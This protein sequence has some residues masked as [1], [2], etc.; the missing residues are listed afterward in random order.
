[1]RSRAHASAIAGLCLVLAACATMR[2]PQP[3]SLQLPEPPK[4]LH[5]TR[6]GNTVV[7]QWT[8]PTATTD[9][10]T[11]REAGPTQICRSMAATLVKC[12]TPVGEAPAPA[13]R[14]PSDK[15]VTQSYTDTLPS[16]LQRENPLGKV[17]YAV[18]VLNSDRRGD[19]VSKNAQVPLAQ[20]LPAPADFEAK[21][22]SQG[23]RLTWA[24]ATLPEAVPEIT[25]VYRVY[26]RPDKT[27]SPT[28]VGEVSVSGNPQPSLLDSNIEWEQTYFYFADVVTI[29]SEPGKPEV[30][31]EGEDSAE[32]KVFTHDVFPPAV[33]TGLQA[34]FSGPGQQAF[35][36][37]VWTPDTDP[38]LAGYNIYRR[39]PGGAPV[40]INAELVRTPS[41]RDTNVV[42][43][44]QYLYSV[45]AVDVRGNESA[46]S[47]ETEENVP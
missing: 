30:R 27:K 3:P 12:G 36:D 23:V 26:R 28:L 34:V 37:L 15:K 19:G 17:T 45:S 14:K 16:E 21:L 8:V 22:E 33:P 41:Y 25:Y 20:T 31:I 40:K 13:P 43:G 9:R 18:E 44:K 2:P 5:A 7:L 38:D 29:I 1:M 11:L 46:R 24:P 39:E 42:S 10:A 6:R 32:V 47:E 4:D 35:I